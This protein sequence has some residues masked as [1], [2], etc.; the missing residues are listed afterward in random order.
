MLEIAFVAA[1]VVDLISIWMDDSLDQQLTTTMRE[2]E[3]GVLDR[4]G[5][6]CESSFFCVNLFLRNAKDHL[7]S[8][9]CR[10][11]MIAKFFPVEDHTDFPQLSRCDRWQHHHGS[12][13]SRVVDRNE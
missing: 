13:Q 9:V 2:N 10:G 3:K 11:W 6:S 8:F 1:V 7:F 4:G 12:K 5:V